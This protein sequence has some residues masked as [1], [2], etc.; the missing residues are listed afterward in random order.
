MQK[1]QHLSFN[2]NLLGVRVM[3][4]NPLSTILQLYCGSSIGG[5]NQRTQRGVLLVEET[6]GPR[7]NHRPAASH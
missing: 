7:E 2:C 5:G 1:Q 6:G 4:F 3:V